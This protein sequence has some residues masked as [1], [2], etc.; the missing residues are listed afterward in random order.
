[1]IFNAQK[2]EVHN[3]FADK[4]IIEHITFQAEVSTNQNA[5]SYDPSIRL[6]SVETFESISGYLNQLEYLNAASH[7]VRMKS[8][9]QIHLELKPVIVCQSGQMLHYPSGFDDQPVS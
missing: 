3:S 8:Q 5:A 4:P 6:H 9:G 7:Q 2:S 1:M